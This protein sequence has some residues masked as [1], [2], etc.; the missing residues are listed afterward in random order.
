MLP[1]KAALR[2]VTWISGILELNLYGKGS[3]DAL[4]DL[5]VPDFSL[6]T[7]PLLRSNCHSGF[8][9]ATKP[10]PIKF[11]FLSR[12]YANSHA[13]KVS[14]MPSPIDSQAL[15]FGVYSDPTVTFCLFCL[16]RPV[17]DL[18]RLLSY[19]F[20]SILFQFISNDSWLNILLTLRLSFRSDLL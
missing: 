9:E 14:F 4:V 12:L 7:N 5:F 17:V 6:T 8:L 10:P 19:L 11:V 1:F 20:L 13:P 3:L 15:F 16:L 18:N 2:S